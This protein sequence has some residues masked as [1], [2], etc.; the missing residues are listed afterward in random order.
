MSKLLSALKHKVSKNYLRQVKNSFNDDIGSIKYQIHIIKDKML[1]TTSKKTY[2]LNEETILTVEEKTEKYEEI[3]KK[4]ISSI[5][6]YPFKNDSPMVSII[7]DNMNG[8]SDMK[9]L[10]KNFKENLGY[11]SYE[12]IVIDNASTDDSIIFLEQLKENLPL[13]II[14]NNDFNSRPKIHNKTVKNSNGKY[15]LLLN[16]NMEPTY[17]WLNQMMQTMITSEDL[18]AVGAKIIYPDCS[19][20]LYN[21]NSFKIKHVGISFK[22]EPDGLFGPHTMGNGLEPFDI[23][24]NSEDLRAAVSGDALL[25]KKEKYHEVAGLDEGYNDGYEDVDL[26]LKLHKHGYNNI[27]C[28]NAILF[29]YGCLESKENKEN[30]VKKRQIKNRA[31]FVEK[32]NKYINNQFLMDKL[33]NRQLFSLKPLKIVFAV[34][35][36]GENASAGDYFTA[37]EFGEGLKKFGWQIDFLPKNGSK[38]WYEVDEDVDVLISLLDVYDPRRI[39]CSNEFLIKIA[40]PRNWFDRWVS[41]PGFKNY[42]MVFAPSK[43]ALEYIKDKINVNPFLLPIATNSNRFNGNIPKK[44]EYECDYCFTGSYWDYPREIVEMLEPEQ[45][46]YKF[47]LYGKNWNKINK[48]QQYYHGF[49]NY[50][51]LPEVYAS[52]KIVIDDAN[53]ATKKYGAV[54]SRVFDALACGALVITNGDMGAEETFKGKLPVFNSKEELNQLIDYYLLNEDIRIAKIEEL[55]KFVLEYHTYKN[56]ANTFKERLELFIEDID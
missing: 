28:P 20:S 48:F 5:E 41:H 29:Y 10:F 52:T 27:Y 25:V 7:I 18:G 37:L 39:R 6:L 36:C 42:D 16:G 46:P 22:K 23:S 35:E 19:N 55:Q 49:I 14:K 26:C 50:S 54:N 34:T 12:V 33:N 53:N 40:W 8:L 3:I 31:L 2:D 11:P 43:T 32:W 38:Y 51:K 30:E 1:D 17:G 47:N 15:I 13:R 21:K 4:N 24:Y 9:R 45:L 44:E 56:R